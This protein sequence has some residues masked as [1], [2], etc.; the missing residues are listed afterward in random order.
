M[1][2]LAGKR[3]VVTGAAT[4]GMGRAI[5]LGYARE[6]ADVAIHHRGEPEMAAE[7]VAA[8]TAMGRR[9]QAFAADFADPAAARAMMR[10]A[11]GW[12]GGIDILLSA[13]GTITRT[14]F[15]DLTDEE[16][17]RVT[18]VNLHGTFACAQEAARAMVAAGKGGRIIAISSINQQK[19]MPM[20]SH[21]AA[22]KGGVMQLFRSMALELGPHGITCNLIAPGA[23]V[24]DLNRQI[25][26]D[27]AHRNRVAAMI[28]LGRVGQPEDMVGAALFL[29]GDDSAWT[30]GTTIFVDGGRSSV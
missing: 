23:V 5:A 13:A 15:L 28:P 11:I 25:M 22:T 7:V 21:Y 26:A 12:L 16:V 20:Q 14:R 29:A 30:S 17:A 19:G 10:Q 1:A 24:T 27:E 6:G 3:A 2:R 9:A 4:N 8:I 18:A